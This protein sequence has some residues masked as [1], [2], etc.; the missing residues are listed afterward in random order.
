M[1]FKPVKPET[2]LLP[3][4]TM[5][6][7]PDVFHLTWKGRPS[8]EVLV[9]LRPLAKLDLDFCSAE[10]RNRAVEAHPFKH[11]DS[12]SNLARVDSYNDW[13]MAYAVVRG[14]CDPNDV[15][16]GWDAW[17]GAGE[18][19]VSQ[20]LTREGI[21]AL[22]DAIEITSLACSPVRPEITPD[23]LARLEI[24]SRRAIER[25]PA[26]RAAR[27]RRILQFIF[28]ECSGYVDDSMTG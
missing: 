11:G 25:M 12:V 2:Q 28:E 14:T 26:A 19:N 6:V 8:N 3:P 13:L 1:P 5:L 10:A 15:R 22:Y 9:G 17:Y 27:T 16:K 18:D 20:M 4:S 23:D 24:I 21:K 7:S